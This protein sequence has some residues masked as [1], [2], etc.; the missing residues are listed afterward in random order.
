MMTTM[1]KKGH[2]LLAIWRARNKF[3]QVIAAQLLGV[4]QGRYSQ[5][6][7][8]KRRPGRLNALLIEDRTAGAV[9]ATS[10]DPEAAKFRRAS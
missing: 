6:E 4:D 10:W 1:P 9:P 7:R 3:S 8:G 2:E 5:Y